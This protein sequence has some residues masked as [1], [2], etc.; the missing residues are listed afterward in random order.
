MKVIHIITGLGTGGAETSLYRLL[1]S[2]CGTS[3]ESEVI[4]LAGEGELSA[5]IAGVAKRVVHLN[6]NPVRPNPWKIL[7]L[8]RLLTRAQPDIV[9]CW[10]YHANL[11]ASIVSVGRDWRLVWGIRQCV[12]NL[13][14]E[15]LSTRQVIKC[16][17]ARSKL[18]D[19][20]VYNSATS[21]KQHAKLGYSR[22]Q[23]LVI[24]NGVDVTLYRRS[25]TDRQRL[26]GEF[27]IPDSAFVIGI[28]G[29]RHPVKDHATFWRAAREL[30]ESL[31]NAY[32]VAAGTGLSEADTEVLEELTALGIRERVRLVGNRPDMPAVYSALDVVTSTSVAEAFPNALLEAMASGCLCVAT[33]VG[34]ARSILG[35]HGIVVE[36]GDA[37]AVCDAWLQLSQLTEKEQSGRSEE[38]R[39]YVLQHYSLEHMK[40][41]YVALYDRFER[42]A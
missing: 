9:H 41:R 5:R 20:I 15:K 37:S 1:Q 27:A 19:V 31:D 28:I 42:A 2:L 6:L 8:R 17:A 16:G 4:V 22:E 7:T 25:N 3:I 34:E 29:R 18:P 10:M 26:R 39:R 38:C 33:D 24:P 30:A 14:D 11:V 21:A 23:E 12:Y 35:G 40:T 36:R 32:F 13:K